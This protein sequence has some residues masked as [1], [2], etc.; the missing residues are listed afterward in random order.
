MAPISLPRWLQPPK[1]AWLR[2]QVEADVPPNDAAVEIAVNGDTLTALVPR[3]AVVTERPTLP[4]PGRVRV[5]LVAELSAD[6]PFGE[7]LLA[8]LPAA[9]VNGGQRIKVRPDWLVA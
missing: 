8:D 5:R 2:C 1:V 3:D 4:S 6:D 9:P 7:G